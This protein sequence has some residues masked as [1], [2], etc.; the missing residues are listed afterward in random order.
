MDE[1]FP[2]FND[3]LINKRKNQK[4]IIA[5]N[6]SL[7]FKSIIPLQTNNSYNIIEIEIIKVK[8][9]KKK[10]SVILGNYSFFTFFIEF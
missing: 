6:S 9:D 4:I 10:N 1:L 2:G 8:T 7:K 5:I 3:I